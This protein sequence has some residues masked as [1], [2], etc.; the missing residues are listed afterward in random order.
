MSIFSRGNKT[1]IVMRKQ[2]LWR[3]ISRIV[4]ILTER[5]NVST[6]LALDIF[7]NTE[8]CSRLHDERYGLYLMSDNY[9]A[10]DVMA[11]LQNHRINVTN[12]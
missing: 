11:E 12:V 7:Y 3:K 6:E 2:V 1:E 9:I 10:N 4:I 8:T 5:L